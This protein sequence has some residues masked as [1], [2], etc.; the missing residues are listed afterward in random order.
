MAEWGLPDWGLGTRERRALG[1]CRTGERASGRAART[2]ERR[3]RGTGLWL[4]GER[5][6]R[7]RSD[8]VTMSNG[9]AD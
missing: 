1:D 9:L 6:R 2:S 8:E 5:R 4:S 7:R 3:E